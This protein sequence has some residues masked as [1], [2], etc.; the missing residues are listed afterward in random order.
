MATLV[1]VL[2]HHFALATLDVRGAYLAAPDP[3]VLA[4]IK[5]V[6]ARSPALVAWD[7]PGGPAALPPPE[8]RQVASRHCCAIA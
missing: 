3:G 5:A 8:H 4:A 2:P 6:L 7:G 1:D